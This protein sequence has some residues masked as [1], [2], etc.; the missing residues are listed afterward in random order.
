MLL[1][2]DFPS[3]RQRA[4]GA[5]RRDVKDDTRLAWRLDSNRGW[6]VWLRLATRSVFIRLGW[7][8][9]HL[10][11]G[12]LVNVYNHSKT[13]AYTTKLRQLVE[14]RGWNIRLEKDEISNPYRWEY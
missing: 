4:L 3:L 12:Q 14:E 9:W 7:H 11:N 5:R 13:L 6:K 10:G 8:L 1:S 2:A